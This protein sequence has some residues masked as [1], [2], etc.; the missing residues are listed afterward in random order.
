MGG[1]QKWVK[2]VSSMVMDGD[3]TFVSDYAEVKECT[4]TSKYNVAHMKLR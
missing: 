4:Q 1:L 3:E 2:G